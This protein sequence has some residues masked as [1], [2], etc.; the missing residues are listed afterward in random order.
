MVSGAGAVSDAEFLLSCIEHGDFK[1]NFAEVAKDLG[2]ASAT[3]AANRMRNLRKKLQE[4]REA[5]EA[6]EG[7][8]GKGG[9]SGGQVTK[10]KEGNETPKPKRGKKRKID[11]ESLKSETDGGEARGTNPQ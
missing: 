4:K 7:K 9:K 1:I 8:G 6:N 3:A 2:Y 5:K 11:G 10:T